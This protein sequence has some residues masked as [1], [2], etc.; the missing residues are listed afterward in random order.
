M[1]SGKTSAAIC[2]MNQ[3]PKKKYLFVTP[4]LDECER[5]I[6]ACPALHFE[7]PPKFNPRMKSF[8]K[9]INIRYLLQAGKNVATTHALFGLFDQET[10]EIIRSQG[11][12]LIMDEVLD[13]IEVLNIKPCDQGKLLETNTISI[14]KEDDQ[15]LWH[16]NEY[17]RGLWNDIRYA[18]ESGGLYHYAKDSFLSL[19]GVEN[20]L[21]FENTYILTYMFEA[22]NHWALFALKGVP[23]EYI[24]VGR[25]GDRYYFTDDTSH[26]LDILKGVG[27]KIIFCG[28][29]ERYA[30]GDDEHA[31][32]ATKLR[33]DRQGQDTTYAELKRCTSYMK[34]HGFNAERNITSQELMW[35]CYQKALKHIS[36]YGITENNFVACNARGKNQ[37]GYKTHLCY[38]VNRY[39]DPTIK[40]FFK[41]LHIDLSDD[42][43]A[44][45]EMIQWIW[46]SAIRNGKEI[47][48][49]IP[50]SRM[51]GLLQKWIE[52][53]S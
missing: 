13:V 1:G 25:D 49:Y 4:Y 19:S 42:D 53:V 30:I 37:W 51:R 28:D 43:F 38:L 10:L 52:K 45:S 29:T 17:K 31:L 15:V 24:G 34:R 32:S 6:E 50:S 21:A 23:Y 35:T 20:F 36:T 16:D 40:N 14:N 18:I 12:T 3:N 47:K 22:Q 7:E 33:A 41:K 39:R 2:M 26:V 48:V 27:D 5:I 8:K 44:L 9:S 46:R 11:Y